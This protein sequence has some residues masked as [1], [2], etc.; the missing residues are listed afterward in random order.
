MTNQYAVAV[1]VLAGM[2]TIIGLAYHLPPLTEPDDPPPDN[3]A[4]VRAV[5][6]QEL[7]Y[8]ATNLSD[9]NCVCFAGMAGHILSDDDPAIRGTRYITKTQLARSQATQTCQ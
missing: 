8:C 3:S 2:F 1:Y 4:H 7:S 5:T 6:L 9:I